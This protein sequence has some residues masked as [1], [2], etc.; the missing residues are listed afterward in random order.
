[1]THSSYVREE[2][3][4]NDFPLGPACE[5]TILISMD[6]YSESVPGDPSFHL[7][8]QPQRPWRIPTFHL[9]DLMQTLTDIYAAATRLLYRDRPWLPQ[10]S[11]ANLIRYRHTLKLAS[12]VSIAI[13]TDKYSRWRWQ[14][15]YRRRSQGPNPLFYLQGLGHLLGHALRRMPGLLSLHIDLCAFTAK[16]VTKLPPQPPHAPAQHG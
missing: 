14:T 12:H 9:A 1:M 15:S 13:L 3:S 11:Q 7:S 6:H 8:R 16:Y 4:F 5:G 10:L 2:Q